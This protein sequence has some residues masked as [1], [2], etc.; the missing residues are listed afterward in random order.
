MQIVPPIYFL[1]KEE[2]PDSSLPSIIQHTCSIILKAHFILSFWAVAK[3]V[4]FFFLRTPYF[5]KSGKGYLHQVS[6]VLT[7]STDSTNC[8]DSAKK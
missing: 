8:T 6:Q 5:T 4:L 1:Q 7:A 2:N 3:G